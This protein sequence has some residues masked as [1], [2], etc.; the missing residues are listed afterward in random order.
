[1]SAK[2]FR[3][4]TG[5]HAGLSAEASVARDYER[6]GYRILHRRW[7]GQSGEVDLIAVGPSHEMAFVEV[8]KSRSF[9]HAAQR[10]AGRQARRICRAAEEFLETQPMGTLTD[11]RFDVALVDA[12]GATQIIE[13]A[14]QAL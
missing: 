7:R 5:F 12:S 10:L 1:M 6:R 13:N 3:S 8:K 11:S 9:D 2:F 14:F 4:Q